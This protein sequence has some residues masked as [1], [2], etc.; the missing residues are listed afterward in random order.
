MRLSAFPLCFYMRQE[1]QIETW[2]TGRKDC[3]RDLYD[4]LHQNQ[5]EVQLHYSCQMSGVRQMIHIIK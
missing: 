3:E 5:S 2:I 4:M 1:P